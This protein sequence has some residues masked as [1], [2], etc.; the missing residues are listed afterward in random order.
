[1][2]KKTTWIVVVIAAVVLFG[3]M[4]MRM[5]HARMSGGSDLPLVAVSTEGTP[6]PVSAEVESVTGKLESNT[7][8]QLAGDMIVSLALNPYPPTTSQLTT[9]DVTLTDSKGEAIND[10]TVSLNLT[11]PEMWMPPNQPALSFVS[12]GKYSGTAPFTMRGWWRIEAVI[13]RGGATQS[14]FFDVGL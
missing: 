9:F 8:A 12:D 14:A 6:I 5:R 2:E 3:V 4:A 13:T 10:A 7:A 11:M 1:M